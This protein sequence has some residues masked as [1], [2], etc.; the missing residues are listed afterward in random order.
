MNKLRMNNQGNVT[1]PRTNNYIHKS[2]CLECVDLFGIVPYSS[3]LC[4]RG[5]KTDPCIK[6]SGQIRDGRYSKKRVKDQEQRN[7]KRVLSETDQVI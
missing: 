3:I 6:R 5:F 4:K 1:C 2:T 7:D